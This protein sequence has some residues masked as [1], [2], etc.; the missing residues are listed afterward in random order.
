MTACDP[1]AEAE[2]SDNLGAFATASAVA[3]GVL[4][5]EDTSDVAPFEEAL[6]GGVVAERWE[7][8]SFDA[9]GA[10]ARRQLQP[11]CF[12]PSGPS[13]DGERRR[14][15]SDPR[16][17][18]GLAA[19]GG[20]EFVPG[21]SGRMFEDAS[22]VEVGHRRHPSSQQQQQQLAGR[23]V[24]GTVG[25]GCGV[26]GAGGRAAGGSRLGYYMSA[27][28]AGSSSDRRIAHEGSQPTVASSFGSPETPL[29]FDG[30][31]RSSLGSS[32][33]GAGG[34]GGSME[35]MFGFMND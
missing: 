2:W 31:P 30:S 35:D 19:F 23:L 21:V 8:F 4:S 28:G 24:P 6:I 17:G 20:S 10:S 14:A 11:G 32:S 26:N 34:G 7:S 5:A 16:Y 25:A 22:G 9:P 29:F 12:S 13:G 3:A 33:G 27:A 15:T 1:T 18:Q